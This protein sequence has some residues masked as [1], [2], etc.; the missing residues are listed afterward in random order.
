MNKERLNF[1]VERKTKFSSDTM[2]CRHRCIIEI[3]DGNPE[4]KK[5]E[6]R[7]LHLEK[8]YAEIIAQSKNK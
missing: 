5:V 8:T 7:K 4:V 6:R 2:H 3:K 1:H